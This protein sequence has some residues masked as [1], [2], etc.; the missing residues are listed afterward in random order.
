MVF[1]K[2]WTEANGLNCAVKWHHCGLVSRNTSSR[3]I[4]ITTTTKFNCPR[5]AGADSGP[6]VVGKMICT[7]WFAQILWLFEKFR[8]LKNVREL[9]YECK[10]KNSERINLRGLPLNNKKNIVRAYFKSELYTPSPIY[11]EVR[12]VKNYNK[13]DRTKSWCRNCFKYK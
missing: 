10:L 2:S 4:E 6:T 12:W 3:T 13:Q 11:N 9:F 5:T 1:L 8:S 7:F